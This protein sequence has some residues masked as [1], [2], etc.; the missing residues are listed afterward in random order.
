MRLDLVMQFETNYKE[1]RQ[2]Y[3][4]YSYGYV[5]IIQAKDM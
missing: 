2:F 1:I 4:N 5:I 3:L